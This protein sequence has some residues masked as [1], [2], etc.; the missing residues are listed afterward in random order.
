MLCFLTQSIFLHEYVQ[1]CVKTNSIQSTPSPLYLLMRLCAILQQLS[2]N[3]PQILLSNC[4]CFAIA[5]ENKRFLKH[6]FFF[7]I[8]LIT[9]GPV[10]KCIGKSHSLKNQ[11]IRDCM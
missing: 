1:L 9:A 4:V 11:A 3:R 6:S 2:I 7:L 8:D 10:R 5:A